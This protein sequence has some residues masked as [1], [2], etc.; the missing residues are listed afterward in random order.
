MILKD[1]WYDI[2]KGELVSD[3]EVSEIMGVLL[4][5]VSLWVLIAGS[6]LV[7]VI[8]KEANLWM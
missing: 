6:E 3:F 2:D 8:L 4:K 7:V 5:D 1:A